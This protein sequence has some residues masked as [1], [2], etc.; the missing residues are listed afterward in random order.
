[1]AATAAVEQETA[2]EDRMS[3]PEPFDVIVLLHEAIER[4]RAEIE[5]DLAGVRSGEVALDV[6][7]V[8]RNV[9]VKTRVTRTYPPGKTQAA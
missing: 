9:I 1:M 5:A 3:T 6:N 4:Q 8:T 2:G 7:L